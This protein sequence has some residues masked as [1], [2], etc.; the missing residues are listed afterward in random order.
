MRNTSTQAAL[1]A[2]S[3]RP[4]TSSPDARI[5]TEAGTGTR[6]P[7]PL[8]QPSLKAWPMLMPKT[9]I[10]RAT[11]ATAAGPKTSG[12]RAARGGTTAGRG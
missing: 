1:A 10:G 12:A 3:R 7:R 8:I 11:T 9:V 5:T 6:R 2:L 4:R